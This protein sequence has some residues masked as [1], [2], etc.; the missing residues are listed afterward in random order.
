MIKYRIHY[1]LLLLFVSSVCFGQQKPAE[2][3]V[4]SKNWRISFA[5]S[6][7]TW[8]GG[9]LQ[10]GLVREAI[11]NIQ[12]NK[13]TTVEADKVKAEGEHVYLN[14]PNDEKFFG[15]NAL[16]ITGVNSNIKFSITGDEI[17]LVQGIERSN[18]SASQIEVY[19]DGTL[20]DT[21]NN[22]NTSPIG[23]ESMAFEGDGKTK[24]FDLG[25]AFT[26][27]HQIRLNDKLL[28]GEHNQGGYGGGAIP[29]G[30][31]Y[32]VIRKYGEG[33][34]GD[35]EVHHWISFR[36]APAKGEKLTVDFSY[37]EEISY[38]KTTIGK[39][40][41]G[42][43]E[44][45]F[46][47]GDVAFDITKPSRVS[48]GLD[49]RETDD[50]A[51]KTYRFENVKKRDV[52]LRIKGNYKGAKGL[53]YFIFNF[54]TNRFFHFQNAGIGGW[55]LTFFNNPD[56]F[57]R[58]YKKIAEFNPDIVYMETTPNDD[59]SVGGY[60][61][62]TEHPE[63]TL[64]ELQSIRTLP[65]KSI[66]YNESSNTYNFQ[67]WVGKI[68]KITANSVTF[69]SDKL[70]QADTPPQQGDYVFLGGYFSNNREYVVRKVEKYDA[71]N[72]QLFFDRPITPD[73]LVYQDIAILKGMEIRVRSFSVFEQEF[74]KFVDQLR[75]LRPE[76]KIASI[77]NPLPI[78]GARELWGYWDFMNDLSKEI[79]FENLKIQP[80]YDY[81][82]SQARDREV[83][84]D[85][86]ALRINPLTGYTEG[87]IEGFDRRNIQNC[88]IIVD[89]KN[90]YGSD[91]VIRNP[92]SYGVDKS[93][94]KGALNMNY[95]KDR[96]LA[97]QKI[98]Q[99]LEV[100]FLKN[101]PKSGKILIK[102][103]TKH[104]S[105]DGCHVRTGDDG[106]KLY[107]SVYYDYFNTL[108]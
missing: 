93:L 34:N 10:S 78:V 64:Q 69:L 90:V 29:G 44:S 51:I 31:D 94:T 11:L 45:P 3:E 101:A 9:F 63:L 81:E 30:L 42:K 17:T 1:I 16:K 39:S 68:E 6:S 27:G 59:W 61:L 19:I 26:F 47:D 80:F 22:W 36:K 86:S 33:K 83:V 57:H 55:K 62:Y 75:A 41:K 50:R 85:A 43:L 15:G 107:G 102:Y 66:T 46:G 32:M 40:D 89:G 76:V 84:I 91:A 99:K 21:I 24:Q 38:E 95:P 56:E 79:D 103:S 52:E 105:G 77:V 104:W 71:A 87:I 60:K 72:H 12:R 106:S 7:V 96:V 97:S 25:R 108:E 65:P 92:Y 14:G 53:P 98:N 49:F 48:S 8:G 2:K 82:F 18:T 73:E 20:Y 100:V 58:G 5:G 54:A 28:A 35:P 13:S 88:E 70:H 37:G 74:R 23:T 4:A 67:K